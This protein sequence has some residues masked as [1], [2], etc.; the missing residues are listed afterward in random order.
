MADYF[1]LP[2][3]RDSYGVFNA[4]SGKSYG[5]MSFVWGDRKEV[6]QNRHNFVRSLGISDRDFLTVGLT[7]GTNIRVASDAD[8]GRV[9]PETPTFNDADSVIITQPEKYLFFCSA[10]CLPVIVFDRRQRILAGV[11]LG[12]KGIVG[13]LHLLTLLKMVNEFGSSI[14]EI[15]VGVGPGICFN[16]NWQKQRVIQCDLPEWHEYVF[17]DEGDKY[18]VNL[19]KFVLDD[20]SS[21]GIDS[22]RI[23]VS[24]FCTVENNDR[25]YSSE[26]IIRN[27][28]EETQGRFAVIFGVLNK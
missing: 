25:I 6:S 13:K 11:H 18:F 16:C 4:F 10:D 21:F 5:N 27:G 22:E 7:H 19:H 23:E 24:S 3:L 1:C 26:G 9:D 14:R 20:F 12:W 28:G 2:G 17:K 8:F 15:C